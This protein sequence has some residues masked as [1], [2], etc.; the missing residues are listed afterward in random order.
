M[1]KIAATYNSHM[2]RPTKIVDPKGLKKREDIVEANLKNIAIYDRA[3]HDVQETFSRLGR[4][5]EVGSAAWT[6]LQAAHWAR[7]VR[8]A[9]GGEQEQELFHALVSAL[10]EAQ[11][12]ARSGY[13]AVGI[14]WDLGGYDAADLNKG[15][16]VKSAQP[17]GAIDTWIWMAV[18]LLELGGGPQQDIPDDLNR[19][20]EKAAPQFRGKLRASAPNRREPAVGVVRAD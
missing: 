6:K 4:S 9:E 14:A 17:L 2:T 13:I 19:A 18:K 15:G 8:F 7:C 12:L 10:K 20:F 5:I 1:R 3:L 11:E 16:R